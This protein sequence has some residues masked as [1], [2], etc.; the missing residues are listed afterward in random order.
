[1]IRVVLPYHLRNLARVDAEVQVDVPAPV[2]ANA[3]IDA[4]ESRYPNLG[5]TIRDYEKRARRPFLR[6][7]VCNEDVSHESPDVELPDAI[8]SGA[9]PFLV[10]GAVAGG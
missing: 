8:R 6:F 2:T 10:V 3:I 1:M 9:E 4:L 7:F 5:G